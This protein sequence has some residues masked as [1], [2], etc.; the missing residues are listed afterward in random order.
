MPIS[1][2]HH[3]LIVKLVHKLLINVWVKNFLN[4]Y[5]DSTVFPTMNRTK[6]T[7]R[8][9][10]SY[11]KII[12]FDLK[13]P[14]FELSWQLFLLD[15]YFLR[16]SVSF[17]AH[18]G[19]NLKYLFI[20]LYFCFLLMQVLSASF[21]KPRWSLDYLILIFTCYF[22]YFQKQVLRAWLNFYPEL[23][24]GYNKI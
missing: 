9:L 10:L 2:Q 16:C 19:L 24:P 11:F 6:S 23:L 4:S 18:L 1:R 14:I 20:P 8:Y 5:I 22:I 7:H 21:N 17:S 13:Y 3:K 15:C 12:Q